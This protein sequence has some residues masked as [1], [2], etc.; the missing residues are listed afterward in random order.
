MIYQNTILLDQSAWDMVLDSNGNIA[1]ASSPYSIAQDVASV[2][3][4][5]IG[6]CWYD[7]SLGLPYWSQILGK[8]PSMSFI[9]NKIQAAALTVPNVASAA[10]SFTNFSNRE[11]TGQ[12]L[13]TDTDN[14]V[15]SVAF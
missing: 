3:R 11:L 5:F 12:I 7:T 14:A 10:V 4:T 13:I 6:E 8:K 2:V 15:N 1:M 9:A